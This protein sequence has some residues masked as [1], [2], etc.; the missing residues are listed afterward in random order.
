MKHAALKW[1][2]SFIP[3]IIS[4]SLDSTICHGLSELEEVKHGKPV[5][6]KKE[7]F[8]ADIIKKS[9]INTLALLSKGLSFSLH[10]CLLDLAGFFRHDKFTSIRLNHIVYDF[11]REGNT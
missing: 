6:S 1:F 5:V 2:L 10:I 9:L 11:F 4:N 3:G 7:P 8:S